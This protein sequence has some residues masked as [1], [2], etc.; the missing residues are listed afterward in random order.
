MGNNR[1]WPYCSPDKKI[2]KPIIEGVGDFLAVENDG[3]VAFCDY[4]TVSYY[5][6]L[7]NFRPMCGRKLDNGE[8]NKSTIYVC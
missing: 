4:G 1:T 6:H 5:E 7:L 2:K 8:S 3:N